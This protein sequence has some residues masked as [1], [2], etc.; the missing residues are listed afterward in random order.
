MSDKKAG[1]PCKG[2][3]NR[4]AARLSD[5]QLHL[6]YSIGHDYCI[7][8]S[9]G[10]VNTSEVLRIILDKIA[11]GKEYFFS[12]NTDGVITFDR[13]LYNLD[14]CI[15]DYRQLSETF[16]DNAEMKGVYLQRMNFLSNLA[17]ILESYNYNDNQPDITQKSICFLKDDD[18][19]IITK[20]QKREK[21]KMYRR[22]LILSNKK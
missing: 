8:D 15:D 14:S 13:I 1:R 16:K 7:Y 19:N 17:A 6:L 21:D 5:K 18:G 4:I 22:N 3:T 12:P 10:T 2:N 9:T 20:I 11:E